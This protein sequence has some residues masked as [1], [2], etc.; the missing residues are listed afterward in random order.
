MLPLE[1]RPTPAYQQAYQTALRQNAPQTAMAVYRLMQL[2][3]LQ[4]RKQIENKQFVLVSLARAGINI[5]ILLKH[6]FSRYFSIDVPHYA[7]SII[8]GRGIDKTA[9]QYLLKRY[10][11]EALQFVDG[12]TGKGAIA[13][14]LADA[15]QEYPNVSPTLAVLADPM[16]LTPFA[17]THEDILIPSACLNAT[18]SGLLS[19]TILRDDLI[20]PD[21]FHGAVFYPE[22][23]EYDQTYAFLQAIEEKLPPPAPGMVYAR[24][25]GEEGGSCSQMKRLIKQI[26]NDFNVSDANLIK[27]GIGET[28]RVLLRRV[29]WKILVRD[30]KDTE[31]LALIFQLAKEKHVPVLAYPLGGYRACGLIRNLADT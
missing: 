5:G 18:V 7:V 28:T 24:E 1:Y 15:M 10:P 22:L 9:M 6:A 20:G 30:I 12:W 21:D 23:A 14:T 2:L 11:P 26:Q 31:H 17:G 25:F 27:P 13:R 16:F 8:R 29:P 3:Y 19:R 4:K